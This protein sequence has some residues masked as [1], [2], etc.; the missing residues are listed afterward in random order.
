TMS[1]NQPRR[2]KRSIAIALISLGAAVGSALGQQTP[3]TTQELLAAIRTPA[4]PATPRINGARVYGAR[5]G[6]PFLFH[7]PATGDRPMQYSAQGLPDG[8]SIDAQ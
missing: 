1:K 3:P 2:T 8:L 4:A 6:R 7:V 5:P